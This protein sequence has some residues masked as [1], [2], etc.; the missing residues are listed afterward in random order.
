MSRCLMLHIILIYCLHFI[1]SLRSAAL[2][3]TG[4]VLLCVVTLC[5]APVINVSA[6]PCSLKLMRSYEDYEYFQDGDIVIGGI[7][8]VNSYAVTYP[9]DEEPMILCINPSIRNY[10]NFLVFVFG[11][12]MMNF[13]E[14]MPNITLGYHLYD[15]CTEPRK[16]VKSVLQILSGPKKTV[17]NY[18]C[19]GYNK[20]AGFIGDEQSITTI[21]IAQILGVYRYSQI[22]LGATDSALNDRRVYPHFFR[23]LQTIRVYYKIISQIIKHFGWNWVGIFTSDDDSGET[24]QLVLS[25]YLSSYGIC[26]DFT[27]KFYKN[28]VTHDVINR[29]I[30]TV[31]S[32]SAQI[33][34]I[35]GAFNSAITVFLQ[36]S[37]AIFYEKTFILNPSWTSNNYAISNEIEAFNKSI[38]IDLYDLNLPEYGGY[39]DNIRISDRPQDTLLQEIGMV[40]Y[41]CMT[42]NVS[43]NQFYSTLYGISLYNCTGRDTIWD[44][45]FYLKVGVTPRVYYAID[46]MTLAL[47]KM[48]RYLKHQFKETN[49]K[50]YNYKSQ[51]SIMTCECNTDKHRHLLNKT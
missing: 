22:S 8:S 15:S 9:F 51:V 12:E 6:S 7:I 39:F 19:T 44:F 50:M 34:I 28:K 47:Q 36:G 29:N 32:S 26:V 4:K 11:I 40:Y 49:M 3:N 46:V 37:P 14:Y 20:V 27:I 21:P 45:K 16:A 18:F 25:E 24:E 42:T 10:V 30:N 48:Q 13:Y 17:P 38:S 2:S 31:R 23:M 1:N 33:I 35:C 5:I 41:N 43:R